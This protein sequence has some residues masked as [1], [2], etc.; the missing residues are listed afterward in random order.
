MVRSNDKCVRTESSALL[1]QRLGGPSDAARIL[2][3]GKK[4]LRTVVS[5]H[6]RIMLAAARVAAT[7]GCQASAT[8]PRRRNRCSDACCPAH[9]PDDE[10]N[11][12]WAVSDL[13]PLI[14]R[15][16]T[17]SST[18][19]KCRAVAVRRHAAI[20]AITAVRG[21]RGLALARLASRPPAQCGRRRQRPISGLLPSRV[22][23]QQRAQGSICRRRLHRQFRRRNPE[24]NFNALYLLP[25]GEI[26]GRRQRQG[27]HEIRDD[28]DAVRTENLTWG[29]GVKGKN[30]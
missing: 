4:R 13:T 22:L 1:L 5:F 3:S 24:R 23:L 19:R 11:R 6:C 2:M 9:P 21:C 18:P 30:H 17:F 10:R 15:C 27:N 16:L 26:S 14:L 20:P 28:G 25:G 29:L 8:G 7:C 12:A